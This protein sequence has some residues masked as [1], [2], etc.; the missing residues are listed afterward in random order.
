[1]NTSNQIRRTF[2]QTYKY[3]T[4]F[5]YFICFF[6]AW[7]RVFPSARSRLP[8]DYPTAQSIYRAFAA[9]VKHDLF[10][11]ATSLAA[12]H[13]LSFGPKYVL[14]DYLVYYL[15]CIQPA[16]EDNISAP[17]ERTEYLH[18]VLKDDLFLASTSFR[19]RHV[20]KMCQLIQTPSKLWI[21]RK[22]LIKT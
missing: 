22:N 19:T 2:Y 10:Y 17:M 5:I 6:S 13:T 1:M 8:Q 15:Q 16:S 18:N 7:Q 3:S 12:W 21:W 9:Q 20:H 14:S 11:W 4:S